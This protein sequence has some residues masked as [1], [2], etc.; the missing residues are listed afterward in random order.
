MIGN[1]SSEQKGRDSV[2]IVISVGGSDISVMQVAN[3]DTY[4][5][6][7]YSSFSGNW[8]ELCSNAAED[9]TK[10][11]LLNMLSG[12]NN[13]ETE[14]YYVLLVGS[15]GL[16]YK[17]IEIPVSVMTNSN[18]LL[19]EENIDQL[20]AI[21]MS[22][23]PTGYYKA[24]YS[25]SIGSVVHSARDSIYYVS[26]A[27]V[28]KVLIEGIKNV[29]RESSLPLFDIQPLAFCIQQ[30]IDISDPAVIDISS[31]YISAT[32]DGGIIIAKFGS[33]NMKAQLLDYI[34]QYTN[35][36]FH[37]NYKFR[38]ITGYELQRYLKKSLTT[39][40]SLSEKKVPLITGAI[41]IA[42]GDADDIRKGEKMSDYIEKIKLIFKR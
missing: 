26:C 1:T 21:C 28:P 6:S 23:L 5:L 20:K 31:G 38:K 4:H 19:N 14:K 35:S 3:T 9:T 22:N 30:A 33:E 24:E 8:Q 16:I 18:D 41:G 27:Y 34:K 11:G 15:C 7:R 32:K 25:V 37:T 42:Y 17:T 39:V 2:A 10:N 29:L 12:F 40:I 36:I 13:Y